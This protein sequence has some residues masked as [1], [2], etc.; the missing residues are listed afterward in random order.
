MTLNDMMEQGITIQ[1][2]IQVVEYDHE[3]ERNVELGTFEDGEGVPNGLRERDIN[4]MYAKGRDTLVVE[5]KGE[6]D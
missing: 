5:L 6:D 2:Q 1:G 4:F 3:K